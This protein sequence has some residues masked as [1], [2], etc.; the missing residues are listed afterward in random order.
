MLVG[1]A[2]IVKSLSVRV[3]VAVWLRA[4]LDPVTVTVKVPAVVVLIVRVEVADPPA[5]N[6]TLVGL[7]VVVTPAGEEVAV[8]DTVPAKPLI[9]VTVMV[10]V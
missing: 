4:P 6:V 8:S 1:L 10:D 7:S 2:V 5:L 9:L 3:T